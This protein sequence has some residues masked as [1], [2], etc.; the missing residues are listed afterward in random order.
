M[1]KFRFI[2]EDGTT[3]KNPLV[4]TITLLLLFFFGCEFTKTDIVQIPL[5]NFENVNYTAKSSV[6][7]GSEV[8]AVSAADPS[9]QIIVD[10]MKDVPKDEAGKLYTVFSGLALYVE[11]TEKV[12]TTLRVEQLIG[13]TEKDFGY[14]KGKYTDFSAAVK[15]FV[16]DKGWKTAKVIVKD[17]DDAAKQVT[18]ASVVSDLRIISDAVRVIRDKKE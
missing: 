2:N 10:S 18:R 4:N 6:M 5:H 7:G 1:N 17:V 14:D 3:M 9:T 13:E 12:T 15:K 11:Q 16:E 8:V